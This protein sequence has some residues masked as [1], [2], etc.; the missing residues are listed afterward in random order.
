MKVSI[1]KAG[2]IVV[3]KAIRDRLG[4]TAGTELEIADQEDALILRPA[5]TQAA[6]REEDGMLVFCGDAPEGFD[7]EHMVDADRERRIRAILGREDPV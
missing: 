1:D 4:L 5:F 3:P 7:W 2:R 6:W